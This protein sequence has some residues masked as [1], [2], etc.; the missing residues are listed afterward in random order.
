MRMFSASASP[1]SKVRRDVQIMICGN[2]MRIFAGSISPAAPVPLR[3]R[4]SVKRSIRRTSSAKR[5]VMQKFAVDRGSWK[6]TLNPAWTYGEVYEEG[7]VRV[8]KPHERADASLADKP[9]RPRP[10]C[11]QAITSCGCRIAGTTN[12][13]LEDKLRTKREHRQGSSMTSILVG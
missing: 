4:A 8:R 1:V 3:R 7:P 13:V 9:P 2:A 12:R 11:G 10:S 6:E 5:L